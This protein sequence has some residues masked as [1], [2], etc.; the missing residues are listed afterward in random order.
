MAAANEKP[1]YQTTMN[2]NLVGKSDQELKEMLTPLQYKVTQEE[3]T[4]RPFANEYWDNKKEGI[5]VDV[6]SGK[7]LFASIHK[8]DS[9]TGWPSFYKTLNDDEVVEVRDSSFGM[10]RTEVRS[11]TGNDHLG[12]LFND[13]PEPTGLRYCINSAAL[14]FIPLEDLEKE[15]YGAYLKLFKDR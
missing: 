9:K 10:V 13:G 6:I 12:H 15:G 11:K 14:R 5:Y 4:E 7:P 3:G 1:K 8:Y 2:H